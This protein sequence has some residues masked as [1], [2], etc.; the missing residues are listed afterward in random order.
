MQFSQIVYLAASLAPLMARG[1]D[2]QLVYDSG[3][4]H[5]CPNLPDGACCDYLDNPMQKAVFYDLPV[6]AG[7]NVTMMGWASRSC[8]M[9][10]GAFKKQATQ[11]NTEFVGSFKSVMW[12]SYQPSMDPTLDN[13]ISGKNWKPE[14][15]AP[16][17]EDAHE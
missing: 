16:L 12:Y 2:V 3:N 7:Q 4:I 5:S 8:P 6:G 9:S 11:A 14:N 1:V 17:T 10:Q 15:Q 13:G